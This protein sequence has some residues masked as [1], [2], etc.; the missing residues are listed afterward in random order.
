MESSPIKD[1]V[2]DVANALS[3]LPGWAVAAIVL[4]LAAVASLVV[5]A[6]VIRLSRR[7]LVHRPGALSLLTGTRTFTQLAFVTIALELVLPAV[8]LPPSLAYVLATALLFVFVILI[9]WIALVAVD[10]GV[11]IYL[12]RFH[13]DSD[14]NLL[15]RKH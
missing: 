8:D 9:G 6:V 10:V 3:F 12:M 13:L 14:D 4:A 7:A 15:A 2:H 5:H 1:A 11:N